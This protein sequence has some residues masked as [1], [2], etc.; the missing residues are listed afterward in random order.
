MRLLNERPVGSLGKNVGR[1]ASR[2]CWVD[3]G[4]ESARR[5]ALRDWRDRPRNRHRRMVSRVHA[6]WSFERE[7]AGRSLPELRREHSQV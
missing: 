5:R 6:I 1:H 7:G 2:G 4:V 3:S